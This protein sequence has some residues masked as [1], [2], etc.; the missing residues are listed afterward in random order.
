MVTAT[1]EGPWT[2]GGTVSSAADR[3]ER[4]LAEGRIQA[5]AELLDDINEAAID[6]KDL[7][8]FRTMLEAL[9]KPRRR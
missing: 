7:A 9:G 6:S 5:A 2:H 3:I 1:A 4:A 8:A